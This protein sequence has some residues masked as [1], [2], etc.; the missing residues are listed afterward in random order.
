M[1]DFGHCGKVKAAEAK[2]MI[3]RSTEVGTH[4]RNHSGA[5]QSEGWGGGG[6][7]TIDIVYCVPPAYAPKL[8]PPF[9][10]STCMAVTREELIG[11][12]C[13]AGKAGS[14]G[15]NTPAGT[16]APAPSA[17]GLDGEKWCL[18]EVQGI[19][20]LEVDLDDL[21]PFG[22]IRLRSSPP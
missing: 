21:D 22:Q 1:P 9:R 4:S 14:L 18:G 7:V 16:K 19:E 15:C 10:R 5:M 11:H 17:D 12:Q 8:R 13:K 20:R 6:G 2:T 3:F